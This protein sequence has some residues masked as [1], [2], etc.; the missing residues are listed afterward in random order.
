MTR[1]RLVAP[2]AALFMAAVAPAQEPIRFARTPDISPDGKLVAFSYLGDIWTVEAIGGV[3]RPVTQHEA[4]DVGPVFSPDGRWIAFSSNRH[5]QY[6]VFVSPAYGGKP[7]RLTFDSAH[8]TALG[9]TPDGKNVVFASSRGT[10]FPGGAELYSVPLEGGRETRLPFHEAK[11]ACYSADGKTVAFT[12]GPG[13]WYRKG[14]RGS[15]NDDLWLATADG[16]AVRRATDFPGNDDSPMLSP[17]GKKLYYVSE[18]QG[19]S[20]NIVY[21]ELNPSTAPPTP[22][23]S[24]RVLTHHK[25]DA[26]RKARLSGNGEWI[27]YECGGDLWVV[28]TRDGQTR[29]LAIE[30]HA[31]EKTNSERTET[32]TR[33]VTE[34]ALSPDENTIA[35]VVHGEV[36]AMPARGGKANRLTDTPAVE[37]GLAW[38]PDSKKLLFISDRTGVEDLY[39]L[40]SDDPETHDL[41]RAVKFKTRALTNTPEPESAASFTPDGSRVAFVRGDKLW[42]IKPDGTDAKVLV[43]TPQVFDYEWSPDGK[44]VAYARSDGSFASELYIMPADGSKPGVNV[45]RYATFNA[46]V[47]WAGNKLA[48]L[49]QRQNGMAV[50]ILSLQKPGTGGG[51]GSGSSA[52]GEIDWDDIHLRVERIGPPASKVAISKNGRLVAFRSGPGLGDLWVGAVDGSSLNR[53]TT[54]VGAS[55]FQWTKGGSIYFLDGSRSIRR[56]ST[57][58][59][60]DIASIHFTAKLPVRQEEEY[61]EVFDQAWRL[62][63]D[64]FYD[65]HHHGAN[66]QAVREKYRPLVRHVAMKEDLYNLVSLM[67]GELNA[68]H[69]GISAHLWSPEEVTADLGL[70]F[71]EAYKGPGLKVAEV[72]KRGPADKRGINL[73]PGDVLLSIDRTELTDKTNL[74]K[75]LNA[76]V[77]ET[78]LLEVTSNPA[79]P[80]AKRKVETQAVGRERI[81]HLMYDRWVEKNAEAVAKQSGGRV[82][83]IHIPSMDEAGLEQFVRALYSDNFDKDGIVI[84]VRYNGGG[85]THD[86]VL[87]YLGAKEHTFFRQRDGNEGLVMR[88]YDR[89]WTKPSAVLIN[90]RSYSDA[91]IFPSAY[92]ALGLGKVVGQATGGMVIGTME[93]SLIDG[94]T[95]RL[96]RTGVYTARGVDME[97]EGVA[98][99]FAVDA[100]PE[101]LAKGTDPQLKKAVEVLGVEVA[102]WKK[103]RAGVASV[104]TAAPRTTGPTIPATGTPMKP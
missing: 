56:A 46:D 74:S 42:T 67:L 15:S 79:D 40:E 73:K 82:G 65:S 85:F 99:D 62:L 26:V 31:D 78:V 81:T 72:L 6:D 71:D 66:W 90:N 29:K 102:E 45:T 11:D 83:Y 12:R 43:G 7:R 32:F 22:S 37:H 44:W 48:F 55:N 53:L 28:G 94:S 59:S 70:I 64:T 97:R 8:D 27:V 104:P 17:D 80:K 3:A 23:G 19:G 60:S 77:N 95:F 30:V 93:T 33:D 1:F 96:P 58:S 68:S 39:L 38:S 49:S 91:E 13:T 87:N 98:P 103:A 101:E 2:L 9:W 92:R 89:K 18:V 14:Y 24:P 41:S 20:A 52:S 35:F 4:H 50:H 21:Q 57:G 100:P 88:N 69:L 16:S 10:S 5:G 84:D 75:L 63:A 36:F 51:P 61:Q 25:D 34:F 86:Q 47:S 54:G 76:K